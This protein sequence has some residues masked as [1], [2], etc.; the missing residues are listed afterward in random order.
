MFFHNKALIQP[1]SVG[2]PSEKDYFVRGCRSP[3]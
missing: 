3:S 2:K 1:V